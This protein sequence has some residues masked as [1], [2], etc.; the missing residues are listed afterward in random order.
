MVP[1]NRVDI[2]KPISRR[3]FCR[4]SSCGL[5]ATAAPFTF[6]CRQKSQ[7]RP[8]VILIITD[9][10]GYGD[11]GVKGNPIIKT[12]NLDRL[13][14]ESAEMSQFYVS[15]V[16]APT[17]ACLLT[18]RYNY[19]T[20]VMDT[21]LGRAMMEPEETT[22]AEILQQ[23]GYATGIFGKWHL[24]DHYPMRPQEQG[25]EHVLVHRGG[26]IGQPSDP[27]NGEG[28]YTDPVLWLNGQETHMSGYCTDVYFDQAME[29][30][31]NVHKQGRSFFAY[32]APNAP[33]A[34]YDDVPQELYETYK[35]INFDNGQFPQTSGHPL[36]HPVN[37]DRMARIYAMISN[38]DQNIGRLRIW[39]KEGQLEQETLI[40]FM[41]DNGPQGRRF[42]AGMRGAKTSVYEGGIRSPLFVYYPSALR[43]G[44]KNERVVAHIDILPTLLDACGLQVPPD[45]HLDG[46]SFWPLL[47][48]R[49]KWPDR[50]LILQAHRGDQPVLYHNF[51]IR[52][53]DWKLL[54]ASDFSAESFS[55]APRF[56][57]YDMKNDPLEM[58][59]VSQHHPDKAAELK[60]AYEAWFDEIGH[61]RANNYEPPDIHVGTAYENPVTLTRQDWRHIQGE[62]S[63]KNSNGYWR[64][65]VTASGSYQVVLRLRPGSHRGKAVLKLGDREYSQ[66]FSANQTEIIYKPIQI[67]RGPV[68]L[69]A[70]LYMGQ[71]TKGPWQVDVIRK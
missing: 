62:P 49:A 4:A 15:P 67:D 3:N 64:L 70:T 60:K 42:V 57:L 41:N 1:F 28:K 59:D 40:L 25:F 29:W 44:H 61:T 8:N 66:S 13:A 9:D 45:L 12:P 63:G 36:D 5:L 47:Q 69:Q 17:R 39:L 20:R 34:P 30:M 35:K 19:R 14:C 33:H 37:Q 50:Y 2:L 21:F 26:G 11:F 23:N 38:I 48:G 31:A 43:A 10:V 71:E 24:G 32:L 65:F 6:S 7:K 58:H 68:H 54:H 51:A 55:G 53:Q 18:G 56:E 52:C 22:L 27:P 16:C 46:R